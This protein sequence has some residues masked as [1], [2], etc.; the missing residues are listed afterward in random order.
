MDKSRFPVL[1]IT[2]LFLLQF[3]LINPLGEF[4]LNDDW[5]HTE[6]LKQWVDTGEFNMNPFAGPSFYVPILYGAG[7]TTWFGFS[8]SILRI[9]T[10]IFALATLILFYKLL[11]DI[12]QKPALSLFFALTLWLNPIFYNLSFTFMTDVPALFFLVAGMYTYYH[13]FQKARP[14]LLFVG[15]LFSVVGMYTR[16]TNILLLGAAGLYALYILYTQHKEKKLQPA[17]QKNGD[18][19]T[20]ALH[21]INADTP[22]K[23]TFFGVVWSFGI[24]VIAAAGIYFFLYQKNLLPPGTALH[25][26]SDWHY[27]AKHAMWWTF[28]AAMYIGFFTL[29]F[30]AGWCFELVKKCITKQPVSSPM[31]RIKQMIQN[32]RRQIIYNRAPFTYIGI[33]VLLTLIIRQSLK[34]QFPYVL[35]IINI[36]GLGPMQGVMNGS[37]TPHMP[38]KVWGIITLVVAASAGWTIYTLVRIFFEKINNAK[39]QN[40]N[41]PDIQIV[42]KNTHTGFIPL[43]GIIFLLPILLLESFDRYFL[44]V[45]VALSPTLIKFLDIRE[46]N[47]NKKPIHASVSERNGFS[48]SESMVSNPHTLSKTGLILVLSIFASYSITQTDFYLNWNRARWDIA[49]SILQQSNLEPHNIDAGYE[50]DGW[51]AFRSAEAAYIAGDKGPF[52]TPWWI[53]HIF[54]NN[55]QDYIVSWSPIPPYEVVEKREVPGANPNNALYLLKKPQGLE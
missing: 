19:H 44:P 53:Y 10:L 28:Y 31:S 34:L 21:E 6:I 7:L 49:N 36:H 54:V 25:L 15:S 4:A 14:S 35:N 2:A 9:S 48:T 22:K 18:S 42:K 51:Y 1:Y 41:T 32:A 26:F 52:G 3:F 16:Q 46:K 12:S 17:H 50:W 8:F 24:P 33:V 5:V 55:T 38:S 29:P 43:F 40:N 39:S 11:K 37:L 20:T 45:F 13:G 47:I 30:S 27:V 23:L